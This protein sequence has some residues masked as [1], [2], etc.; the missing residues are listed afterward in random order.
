MKKDKKLTL[1]RDIVMDDNGM[2]RYKY[3]YVDEDGNEVSMSDKTNNR[4]KYLLI[5]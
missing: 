4:K 1:C 3:Y 2:S 5:A